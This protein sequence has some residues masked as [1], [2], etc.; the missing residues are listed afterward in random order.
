MDH[1]EPPGAGAEPTERSEATPSKPVRIHVSFTHAESGVGRKHLLTRPFGDLAYQATVEQ[2]QGDNNE[3]VRRTI[4]V[5]MG[6]SS[7][8]VNGH[9]RYEATVAASPGKAEVVRER[10][11]GVMEDLQRR[12]KA[13]FSDVLVSYADAAETAVTSDPGATV[14]LGHE[15]PDRDGERGQDDRDLSGA[16]DIRA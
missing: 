5:L 10:L 2:V 4:G 16:G 1:G 8:R 7:T 13:G 14:E 11:V 12:Y 6:P 15:T 3:T 9:V